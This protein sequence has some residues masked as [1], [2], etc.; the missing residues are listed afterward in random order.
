MMLDTLYQLFYLRREAEAERRR[1][2]ELENGPATAEIRTIMEDRLRRVEKQRD[3][4]AAYIDAIEDDFIRTGISKKSAPC[5]AMQW[6]GALFPFF[7][8]YSFITSLMKPSMRWALSCLICSVKWAYLS[9]VK[10]AVAWPRLLWMVFI[11]S[12]A[13]I[14]LTA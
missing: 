4:L 6:R 12:P 8:L 3:R 13:R 7:P 14:A 2:Q 1:L 9:R 10:A 5:L 11:S